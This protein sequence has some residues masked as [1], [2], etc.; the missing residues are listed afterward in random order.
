MRGAIAPPRQVNPRV[1]AALEA[2][3]QKAMALRPAD[4]YASA[5]A[6]AEEVERWLA[7]E[8]V[9]ARREPFWEQARRWTRRRRTSMAVIAATVLASVV[10]LAAVLVVQTRA[11]TDLKSAN[12]DLAMANQRASDANRELSLANAR[13]RT[14][15]DLALDAIKTFHGTVGE[16]CPLE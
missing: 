7:D 1:P 13:E 16:D 14:R 11:N 6:L 3:V 10:G 2:I 5:H 4:R 9:R 8:P 15:F 12:L